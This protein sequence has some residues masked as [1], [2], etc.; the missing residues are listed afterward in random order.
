MSAP[1]LRA[2]G[3]TRTHLGESGLVPEPAFSRVSLRAQLAGT[4]RTAKLTATQE[5][6]DLER[7][8]TYHQQRVPRCTK[9]RPSF[10]DQGMGKAVAIP[11]CRTLSSPTKKGNLPGRQD[12][13]H[14]R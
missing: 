4:A 10:S 8:R 1:A 9:R 13:R 12:H 2:R 14:P 3:T 5:P 11:E 6:V 7:A